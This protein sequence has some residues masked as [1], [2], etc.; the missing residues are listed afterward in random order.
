MRGMGHDRRSDN[1]YHICLYSSLCNQGCEKHTLGFLCNFGMCRSGTFAVP[2]ESEY[3]RRNGYSSVH[4]SYTAVHQPRRLKHNLLMGHAC[5]DKIGRYQNI[6]EAFQDHT[7][8]P[9]ALSAQYNDRQEKQEEGICSACCRAA[10][11]GKRLGVRCADKQK[12]S[13]AGKQ[14]RCSYKQKEGNLCS[15]FKGHSYITEKIR[16]REG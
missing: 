1:S 16:E 14:G 15:K 8:R 9:S 3:F 10:G 11:Q 13:T 4:G 5:A 2:D 6:S 7:S 12:D